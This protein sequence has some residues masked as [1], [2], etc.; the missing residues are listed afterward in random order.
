MNKR[1]KALDNLSKAVRN[2][3]KATSDL[4]DIIE[5]EYED[6]EE[7]KAILKDIFNSIDAESK[8]ESLEKDEE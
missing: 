5:S 6:P 7:L 3:S 2:L 4:K 1:K 8:L